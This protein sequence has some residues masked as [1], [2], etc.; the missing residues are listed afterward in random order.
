M[1]SC[2]LHLCHTKSLNKAETPICALQCATFIN[3]MYVDFFY[4]G[5]VTAFNMNTGTSRPLTMNKIISTC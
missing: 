5:S 4:D 3:A 2:K 1:K